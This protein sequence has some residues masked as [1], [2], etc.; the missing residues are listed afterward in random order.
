MNLL[1]NLDHGNSLLSPLPT[2]L[3]YLVNKTT[4]AIDKIGITS[5]PNERYSEA[6]LRAENVE[7]VEKYAF[8]YRYPAIVAENIEL[9][10]YFAIHGTLPRLNQCFN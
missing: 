1:Y 4:G 3:Y 2:E 5:F 10:H 8:L 7:Y 6:W 9:V